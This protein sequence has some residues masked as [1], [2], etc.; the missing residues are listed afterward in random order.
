MN[1]KVRKHTLRQLAK[2]TPEQVAADIEDLKRISLELRKA[3]KKGKEE[4]AEYYAEPVEC[5]AEPDEV[6]HDIWAD[7]DAAYDIKHRY[8]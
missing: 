2:R 8:Q 4:K 5:C 6:N 1:A 3:V 7:E